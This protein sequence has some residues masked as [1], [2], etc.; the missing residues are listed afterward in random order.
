M[1]HVLADKLLAMMT[2]DQ[3]Y[4]KEVRGGIPHSVRKKH[5]E[6]LKDIIAEHG[7][8]TISLVGEKASQA[9]WLL[10]QHAD[11]DVPFQKKCLQLIT[12]A[13][14]RKEVRLSNFAY[15]TDRVRVNTG[16]LQVFG[17]QLRLNKE[18]RRFEPKPIEDPDTV[19]ERRKTYDLQPATLAEYLQGA[20][21]HL[22]KKNP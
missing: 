10:A 5:A 11:H 19:D 6:A 7:W 14:D 2:E 3:R 16:K 15:L 20:E 4:A 1:D 12:Q 13:V 22:R 8:P 21:Q 9:A 18:T 17:T